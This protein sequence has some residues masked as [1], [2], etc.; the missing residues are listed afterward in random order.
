M[1]VRNYGG[2]GD[3]DG[4]SGGLAIVLDSPDRSGCWAWEF[5]A[6]WKSIL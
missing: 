4:F 6:D 1:T 3:A 5:P 2:Y